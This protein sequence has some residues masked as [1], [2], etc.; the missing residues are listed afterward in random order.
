MMAKPMKTLELHYPMIQFLIISDSPSFSWGIFAHVTSLDQSRASE[1]I[2]WI[3]IRGI[4]LESDTCRDNRITED[5]RNINNP[6]YT[7]RKRHLPR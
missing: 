3:I 4:P 7:T 5:V 2:W 6:W 1:E